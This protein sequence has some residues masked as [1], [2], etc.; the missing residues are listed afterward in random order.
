MYKKIASVLFALS[1]AACGGGG[2]S[3][4]DSP[5]LPANPNNTGAAQAADVILTVSAARLPNTG[6]AS[7][8]VTATAID[9]SRNVISGTPVKLS[10]DG[11]AILASVSGATTGTDG[12]VSAKLSTGSN[13]A[14]RVITVTAVSAG[15]TKTATVQVAGT[16]ITAVLVPAVVSPGSSAQVQYQVVDSAGSVMPNEPIRIVAADL[17]PAEVT[18]VTGTSGEF[19]YVYTAPA[20][21]G[22]F[23]VVMTAGGE[24]NSQSITVQSTGTVPNVT[25]PILSASVSAAPSVVAVNLTGGT[26]NRSEIRALFLSASNQPLANVRARFDLNGDAFSVGGSFTTGNTRLYSDASGV[27]T[28]AYVPGTRSSPTNGVQVR[29]CYGMS[30][31]DPNFTGCLTSKVVT[32]TVAAEPLGVAIGTNGTIIVTDLTYIKQYVVSVADAAGN[33]VAD[34]NLVASVD[35]PIYRKGRYAL[36]SVGGSTGWVQTGAP[37]TGDAA[38]C[39]NEDLNRNG[40]LDSGDDINGDGQ[41]WPRKPD[42]IIRLLQTKTRVDGTAVLQIEYAQDHGSWVDAMITVS[43]SGVSGSE[44]RASY[45]AAPVPVDAAAITNTTQRPAFLVS[46][47]G[48]ATSCADP[49]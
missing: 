41:L 19:N 26:A 23:P 25:V 18:G 46:P 17:T 8:D 21:T 27:V 15:I 42:V 5:F 24:T 40:A 10:A 12:V 14:T 47:Y 33:A 44:G 22:S 35:L 1:M 7:V 39:R 31:T 37:P 2:G 3:A 43:A 9:A 4:G 48:E 45:L 28:T 29:V 49:R 16:K 38:I 6:T 20:A 32:L 34:V 36:G 11:D 30:D 13:R